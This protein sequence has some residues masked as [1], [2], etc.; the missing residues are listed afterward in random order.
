MRFDEIASVFERMIMVK[1]AYLQN[2]LADGV[3]IHATIRIDQVKLTLMRIRAKNSQ[4]DGLLIPVWDFYGTVTIVNNGDETTMKRT[5]LLTQCDRWQ[6]DR[7]RIGILNFLYNSRRD[8]PDGN[9]SF[10]NK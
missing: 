7:P 5:I 4:E 9:I 8:H 2:A 6:Y 1:Y 10:S 3:D